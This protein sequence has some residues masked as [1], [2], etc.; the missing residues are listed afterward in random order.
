METVMSIDIMHDFLPPF[1]ILKGA[2][3]CLGKKVNYNM[4]MCYNLSGKSLNTYLKLYYC[5][6]KMD[7]PI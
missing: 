1:Y 2:R 3:I 5:K 7:N 6:V 4:Y